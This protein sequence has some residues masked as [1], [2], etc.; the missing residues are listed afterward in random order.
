MRSFLNK[1]FAV[2]EFNKKFNAFK[3][4]VK[5]WYD[6]FAGVKKQN[7]A[8]LDK[9][10]NV[11]PDQIKKDFKADIEKVRKLAADNAKFQ[12]EFSG[13]KQKL[14]SAWKTSKKNE[15]LLD[16]YLKKFKKAQVNKHKVSIDGV[17]VQSH[18]QQKFNKAF[19]A[20]KG[21]MEPSYFMHII[22][23]VAVVAGI[24]V[25]KIKNKKV[26]TITYNDKD[27][28]DV[29]VEMSYNRRINLSSIGCEK[30]IVVV[31]KK[32]DDDIEFELTATDTPVWYSTF[33][34]SSK[35]RLDNTSVLVGEGEYMFYVAEQAMNHFC[36][37]QLQSKN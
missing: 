16:N 11:L 24:V 7:L 23:A 30:S 22:I 21:E 34:S 25:W 6:K 10:L 31:C 1:K 36:K 20:L 5:A 19:K 13:L 17:R 4:K 18:N 29:T 2:E 28:E 14:G 15:K 35:N 9:C 12:K 33:G 26:A 37:V 8:E 3:Q 27:K 32:G